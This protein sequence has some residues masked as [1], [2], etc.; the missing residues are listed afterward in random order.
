MSHPKRSSFVAS[1]LNY[2]YEHTL[3][4]TLT[5]S[6]V[7]DVILKLIFVNRIHVKMVVRV[8]PLRELISWCVCVQKS[9]TVTSVNGRS[10]TFVWQSRRIFSSLEWWYNSSTLISLLMIFILLINKCTNIFLQQSNIIVMN[11]QFQLLSW[12]KCILPTRTLRQISIFYHCSSMQSP[13][14]AKQWCPRSI[15]VHMFQPWSKVIPFS[16]LFVDDLHWMLF[17]FFS[18][19]IS[20]SLH[21]RVE[22]TVFSRRLLSLYL[23]G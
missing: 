13:S 18:Y 21:E 10:F 15:D 12:G 14:M 6:M 3:T 20:S 4:L 5:L 22:F 1:I 16:R 11:R 2:L 19:S 23:R 9:I 17:R 8:F 7:L